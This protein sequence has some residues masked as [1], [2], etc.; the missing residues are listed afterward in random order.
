MRLNSINNLL[1]TVICKVESF[2]LQNFKFSIKYLPRMNLRKILLSFSTECLLCP[3]M[4]VIHT[5]RRNNKMTFIILVPT[6][7]SMSPIDNDVVTQIKFSNTRIKTSFNF[8]VIDSKQPSCICRKFKNVFM[9][10]N[11][12]IH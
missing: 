1:I 6:C 11:S 9:N 10:M 5:H 7:I 3:N 8:I 4:F 2:L 12:V